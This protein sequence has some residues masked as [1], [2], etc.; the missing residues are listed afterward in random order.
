MTKTIIQIDDKQ[1]M[2]NALQAALTEGEKFAK[3]MF[4]ELVGTWGADKYQ[5]NQIGLIE[6]GTGHFI[7]CCQKDIS[8]GDPAEYIADRLASYSDGGLKKCGLTRRQY[9]EIVAKNL[10]E[11]LRMEI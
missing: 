7:H 3:A 10:G 5:I 1:E 11:Q 9:N 2:I 6:I 8:V 4:D